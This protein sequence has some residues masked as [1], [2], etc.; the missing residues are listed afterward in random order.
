MNYGDDY[1]GGPNVSNP[2]LESILLGWNETTCIKK[3]VLQLLDNDIMM[4]IYTKSPDC[5]RTDFHAQKYIR[6]IH[7]KSDKDMLPLH[8]NQYLTVVITLRS[9]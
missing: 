3:T 2:S 6:R 7:V 9:Q 1:N 8:I 5:L 4:N